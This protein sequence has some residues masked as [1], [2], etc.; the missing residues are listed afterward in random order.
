MSE[1]QIRQ[2]LKDIENTRKSKIKDR[3]T[4]EGMLKKLRTPKK[5]EQPHMKTIATLVELAFTDKQDIEDSLFSLWEQQLNGELRLLKIEKNFE[6]L[7]QA[8][9]WS[10]QNK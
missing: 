7:K 4:T 8:I 10:E 9:D 5:L 2:K 6:Q 1:E 3:A